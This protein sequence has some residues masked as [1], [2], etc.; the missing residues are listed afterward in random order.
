MKWVAHSL[1]S[2]FQVP[3]LGKMGENNDILSK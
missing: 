2:H 1:N 3:E